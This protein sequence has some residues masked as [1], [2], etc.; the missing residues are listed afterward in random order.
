MTTSCAGFSSGS[1][2][3]D[4]MMNRP[5]GTST[6]SGQSGQSRNVRGGALVVPGCSCSWAT[7]RSAR[8]PEH[9]CAP[10]AQ[11]PP[12]KS[13]ADSPGV[14]GTA[15]K[16]TASAMRSVMPAHLVETPVG[17]RICCSQSAVRGFFQDDHNKKWL[18]LKRART[19]GRAGDRKRALFRLME[20]AAFW[21]AATHRGG[22]TGPPMT[23]AALQSNTSV[24]YSHEKIAAGYPRR[25][26]MTLPK[27]GTLGHQVSRNTRTRVHLFVKS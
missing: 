27:D 23:I 21:T 10:S 16:P 14:D 12:R 4:P 13:R 18:L 2:S 15:D 19:V 11:M 7:L 24:G 25:P 20:K 6:I 26:G 17:H 1:P 8:C 3:A 22:W 5:A 9:N